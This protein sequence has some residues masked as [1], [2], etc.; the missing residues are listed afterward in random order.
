M[1]APSPSKGMHR[2]PTSAAR[3]GEYNHAGLGIDP[4][5]AGETPKRRGPRATLVGEGEIFG[6]MARFLIL[7]LIPPR[8]SRLIHGKLSLTLAAPSD[9][10]DSL[11]QLKRHE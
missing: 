6:Q 7:R 2:Y 11:T 3:I 10:V 1:P 9:D 8:L 5:G 4:G